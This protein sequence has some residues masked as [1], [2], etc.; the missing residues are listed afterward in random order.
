MGRE[1]AA[2]R[3]PSPSARR[4]ALAAFGGVVCALD[5]FLRPGANAPPLPLG[6]LALGLPAATPSARPLGE[7]AAVRRLCLDPHAQEPAGRRLVPAFVCKLEHGEARSARA[8]LPEARL[9]Q[10]LPHGLPVLYAARAGVDRAG[11]EPK[12]DSE[13][14]NNRAWSDAGHGE[15]YSKQR[16]RLKQHLSVLRTPAPAAP[17]GLSQ[18]NK[19]EQ[20]YFTSKLLVPTAEI[21]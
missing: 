21:K 10:V 7:A 8:R 2:F 19:P 16:S 18:L 4:G 1:S 17:P 20:P 5:E 13:A 9:E 6:R 15:Q 14:D 3:S 11:E 12:H